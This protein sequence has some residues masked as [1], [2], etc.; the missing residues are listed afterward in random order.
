[1]SATKADFIAEKLDM[2]ALQT[3]QDLLVT[4]PRPADVFEQIKARLIATFGSSAESRLRQLIKGQVS[5]CGKPSLILTRLRALNSGCPPEVIRTIFLDQLPTP[6]RTALTVSE[7]TDFNR[8]AEMADKYV[9]ASESGATQVAAIASKEPSAF[10]K[11]E[12]K[13]DRLTTEMAKIKA[14]ISRG[15]NKNRIRSKSRERSKSPDKESGDKKTSI[16][17]THRK[18]GEKARFCSKPC[19]WKDPED[20]EN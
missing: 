15:R 9:E 10:D 3:V 19:S 20:S 13:I 17:R 16:C 18:F 8:L 11:L 6:C 12:A 14:D 5:T 4:E 7:V 1:M 2:E